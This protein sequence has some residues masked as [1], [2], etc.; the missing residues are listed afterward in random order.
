M[1]KTKKLA[2]LGV[3]TALAMVLSYVEFLI[4]PLTTTIPGIKMGLA[5]IVTVFLI[6]RIGTK[7]AAAVSAVR[8]ALSALLFGTAVS[9]AYSAAGAVFSIAGMTLLKKTDRFSPL[10]VSVSGGVLHNAGQTI[11]AILLLGT[12]RLGYYFALLAV[13]GTVSGLLVGTAAWIVMKSI[14]KTP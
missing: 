8:V 11:A 2:F 9:L 12:A 5:N 13:S 1:S 7:E 3:S 6:Y 4:P 14:K 10:G